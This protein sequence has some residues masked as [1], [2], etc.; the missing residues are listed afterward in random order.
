M[1]LKWSPGT[2]GV[3]VAGFAYFT[4]GLRAA[5][6][7]LAR[8]ASTRRRGLRFARPAGG[9]LTDCPWGRPTR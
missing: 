7:R 8:S 1:G 2:L 4:R 5:S 6:W 3:R 9:D